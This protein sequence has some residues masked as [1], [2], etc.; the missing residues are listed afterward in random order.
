MSEDAK[1][2]TV[3]SSEAR[4]STL[5]P[6]LMDNY[7]D[8][9]GTLIELSDKQKNRL[10]KW[11]K[12][13]ISEWKT[14]TADLHQNLVFDN[15][16][17]EGVVFE[18]DY[19]WVGASNVHLPLT[20]IYMEIY[21]SV[22]KRSIL[23]ANNIWF[24]E[25]DSEDPAIHEQLMNAEEMLNYK[26]RNEWNIERCLKD[27]FWITNRDGLGSVEVTWEEKYKKVSDVVLVT[28]AED[29][30]KEFPT[31]EEA[32]LT[33]DEYQSLQIEAESASEETPLEIPI[34]FE[35]RIYYGCKGEAIDLVNFVTI[36][37]TVP[38]LDHE[39]CRGFGKRYVTRS[40]SVRQKIKDGFYYKDEAEALL[41]KS[42]TYTPSDFIRAQDDMEGLRR[43]N[44]KGTFEI[45][46]L[47]ISVTLNG[48]KNEED[49]DADEK[50][51]EEMMFSVEYDA[52]N[53]KLLRCIEYPYRTRHYATFR[54]DSRPNR[55]VGKSVPTK[56]RELNDASDTQFNQRINSR[57]ISTIPVFKGL[58]TKKDELDF[59]LKQQKFKPGRVFWVSDFNSFDQFKI[60]PTDQGES[61]SE[62]KNIQAILDLYLGSAAS[63][64]SGGT[65]AQDP[66]APGNKTA[67]MISQSNLRM[68]D[69]L[70]ELREG[71]EQVG[72]ICLSHLYQFGGPVIRFMSQSDSGKS[73]PKT[74]YK[75]Y[76]RNAIRMKMSGIS[77]IQNPEVEK[78][79][80]LMTHQMLMS[81][82][83][84][85]S[86]EELRV[87]GLRA[88][89]RAGRVQGRNAMLPPAETIKQM[90]IDIQKKAL[91]QMEMEK[92]AAQQAQEQ[93]ALKS[94]LAGAK[95]ELDIKNTAS[96]LA[97]KGFSLEAEAPSTPPPPIPSAPPPLVSPEIA[98]MA[99]GITRG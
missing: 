19:P 50:Y 93:E 29:F 14:D 62:E 65:S 45:F 74:I 16:L 89:L 92:Q 41:N 46:D 2:I 20:E 64:L 10:K 83:L 58:L 75:K 5:P 78:Q 6:S 52:E 97:E 91:Q 3:D 21:K 12:E 34:T 99:G 36:P 40:A 72:N 35:K 11:L 63:L 88:V 55:L 67:M 54:I 69:P 61:M 59:E 73:K 43:T 77:V 32:G 38:S 17:V 76:L 33:I 31:P 96:K 86:N 66:N 82:P 57:T 51:S 60:Q 23:G 94:R 30:E 44:A 81:E 71:I 18:T 4:L 8:R 25:T 39:L 85:A 98:E 70:D 15:D 9:L 1:K 48:L 26:A 28:S 37:A 84:Y 56:T 53:D 7:R 13:K 87:N 22:E 27:V 49:S 95:Q 68:D 47:H 24:A 79:N 80:A 42:N 90:Q